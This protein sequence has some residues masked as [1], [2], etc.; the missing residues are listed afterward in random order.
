MKFYFASPLEGERI[1]V[2][3]KNMN[4][5]RK[6]RQVKV[7]S[8]TIGGDAPVRIQSMTTTHTRDVEATVDLIQQLAEAGCEM[9]RVACPTEADAN[10]T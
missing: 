10:P 6:S 4:P 1:K 3:G 2:R 9:V 5:R 7:G 8:V